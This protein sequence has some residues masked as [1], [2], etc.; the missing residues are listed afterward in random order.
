M[1]VVQGVVWLGEE[2]LAAQVEEEAPVGFRMEVWVEAEAA[3]CRRMP[4]AA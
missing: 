4:V 1:T 2:A 3:A